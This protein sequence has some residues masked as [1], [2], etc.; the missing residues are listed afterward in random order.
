MLDIAPDRHRLFEPGPRCRIVTKRQGE[1]PA[2]RMHRLGRLWT[3]LGEYRSLDEEL[4]RIGP[5]L[6]SP[7]ADYITGKVLTVDGG[8]IMS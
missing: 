8:L 6:A 7:L 3:Y 2:G 4:E 5:D 1:L